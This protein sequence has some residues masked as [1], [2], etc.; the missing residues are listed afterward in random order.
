VANSKV[1]GT[2]N[3]VPWDRLKIEQRYLKPL[4]NIEGPKA[5]IETR[6]ATKT[7]LISVRNNRYSIPSKLANKIV[8][9]HLYEDHFNIYSNNCLEASHSYV[10][11]T[12]QRIIID[13]HYPAHAD[14]KPRRSK[15][16]IEFE[17][18]A[19]EAKEYLIELPAKCTK[20]REQMQKIIE[21]KNSYTQDQIS[22][23]MRR[24]L[25]YKAFGYSSL[26]N[27]LRKTASCPKVLEIEHSDRILEDSIYNIGVQKRE[28]SYYGGIV[29]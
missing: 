3:E 13:K 18:L 7:S 14:P 11:G 22:A 1:H 6:K 29:K 17:E 5:I 10:N 16:E 2:T 9:V 27:I 28:L 25:E 15:L 8:Q 26:K 23:G 24:A 19:P 4:P 12:N 21:L 20:L